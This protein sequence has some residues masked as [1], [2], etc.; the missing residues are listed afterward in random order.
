MP[1][2]LRKDGFEIMIYTDDHEPEHVHIHKAGKELIVN[3]GGEKTPISIREVIGMS[4]KDT[5]KAVS[6]VHNHQDYLLQ[7]WSEIHGR[8]ANE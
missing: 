3:L 8:L 4:K 2:I 7:R 1:T 6:I 5:R